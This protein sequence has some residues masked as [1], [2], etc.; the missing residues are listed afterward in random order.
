M[1]KLRDLDGRFN[2]S[3]DIRRRYGNNILKF[4]SVFLFISPFVDGKQY[5]NVF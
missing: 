5:L 1:R 3:T 4:D 2:H